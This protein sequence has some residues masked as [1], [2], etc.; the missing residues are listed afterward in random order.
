MLPMLLVPF[1]HVAG[2]T[3]R[4]MT[5]PTLATEIMKDRSIVPKDPPDLVWSAFHSASFS[6]W[7][8]ENPITAI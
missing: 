4:I 8:F 1:V 5:L 6:V 3:P 2:I 7:L